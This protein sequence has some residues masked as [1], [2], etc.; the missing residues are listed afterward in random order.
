MT[1]STA[2]RYLAECT[3]GV[4]SSPSSPTLSLPPVTAHRGLIF[5]QTHTECSEFAVKSETI[6]L[7]QSAAVRYS[8]KHRQSHP[9]SLPTSLTALPTVHSTGHVWGK[10]W[11][12]LH[13]FLK[14][15]CRSSQPGIGVVITLKRNSRDH[16]PIPKKTNSPTDNAFPA[17]FYLPASSKLEDILTHG[18]PNS[19]APTISQGEPFYVRERPSRCVY[20][21]VCVCV[22]SPLPPP[23]PSRRPHACV[24]V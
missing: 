2:V 19:F 22:C 13:R 17:C 8:A 18:L 23:H 14:L 12:P 1:L 15:C 7:T 11:Q 5:G 10:T 16:T 3:G 24:T 20:V 9:R 4:P 6:T 21:C